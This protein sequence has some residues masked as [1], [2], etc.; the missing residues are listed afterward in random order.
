MERNEKTSLKPGTD[1]TYN[2]AH[3]VHVATCYGPVTVTTWNLHGAQKMYGMVF[4]TEFHSGTVA[5]PCG[6]YLILK[7]RICYFI[8]LAPCVDLVE[9]RAACGPPQS[10][11]RVNCPKSVGSLV[12]HRPR[13]LASLAVWTLLSS[14]LGQACARLKRVHMDTYPDRESLTP[15]IQTETSSAQGQIRSCR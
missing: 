1:H 13:C 5:R 3:A 14:E 9:L 11:S 7:F 8:I 15:K 10:L 2:S 4:G 12:F 6:I